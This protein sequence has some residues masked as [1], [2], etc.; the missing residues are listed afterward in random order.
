MD[1]HL[2]LLNK[3][4]E[5]INVL[6]EHYKPMLVAGG[7]VYDNTA[8]Q[9]IVDYVKKL[10]EETAVNS[11]NHQQCLDLLEELEGH[12]NQFGQPS[13]TTEEHTIILNKMKDILNRLKKNCI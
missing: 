2:E 7:P 6:S 13:T 10:A 4:E 11:Q 8:I 3:I 9:D 1:N 12:L 5:L